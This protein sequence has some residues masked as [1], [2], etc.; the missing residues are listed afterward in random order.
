M[1]TALLAAWPNCA[2]PDCEHKA[3]VAR[4]SIYCS[5]CTYRERGDNSAPPGY[6]DRLKALAGQQ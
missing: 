1:N 6:F 2:T 4:N 5:P 3:C